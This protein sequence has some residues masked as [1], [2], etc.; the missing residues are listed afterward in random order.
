[1]G[2]IGSC[3]FKYSLGSIGENRRLVRRPVQQFREGIT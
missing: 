1:M 2:K 3:L